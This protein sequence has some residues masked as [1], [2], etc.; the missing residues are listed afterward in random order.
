MTFPFSIGLPWPTLIALYFIVW[1]VS[2]FAVLPIGVQNAEEAGEA[3]NAVADPGAPVNPRLSMK[4]GITSL[5][6]LPLTYAVALVITMI[7]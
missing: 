5:V 4:A 7:D 1:W 3:P 6:A 2:L